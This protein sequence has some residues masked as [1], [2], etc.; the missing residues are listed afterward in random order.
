MATVKSK[1]TQKATESKTKISFALQLEFY[2]FKLEE[3]WRGDLIYP[4]FKIPFEEIT[5]E[6]WLD[7]RFNASNAYFETDFEI[8]NQDI[9]CEEA[10]FEI[11]S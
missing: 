2:L 8:L 9:E 7:W 1:G 3:G 10:E 5:I 6:M 11:I 4:I